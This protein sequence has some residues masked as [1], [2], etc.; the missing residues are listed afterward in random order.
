MAD[1]GQE[2]FIPSVS[3]I[4]SPA[5]RPTENF[6][7]QREDPP[8]PPATVG[9]YFTP[10]EAQRRFAQYL[11]IE[12]T[13]NDVLMPSDDPRVYTYQMANG[14][15]Y[16]VPAYEEVLQERRSV[17]EAF[18]HLVDNFP[19]RTEVED[20][21]L[22]LPQAAYGAV[23]NMV[24]GQGTYEDV[25]GTATGMVGLRPLTR[26]RGEEPPTAPRREEPDGPD[27]WDGVDDNAVD[28][29][30]EPIGDDPLEDLNIQ[31]DPED[32]PLAPT[33]QGQEVVAINDLWEQQPFRPDENWDLPDD[34]A[35][36]DVPTGNQRPLGVNTQ[37]EGDWR[38]P[39]APLREGKK[40][41][42][43]P[44]YPPRDYT[45]NGYEPQD[46]IVFRS[47][48]REFV[49]GVQIPAQGIKGSQFLKMLQDNPSIRN[50]EVSYLNLGISPEARYTREELQQLVDSRV[51]QVEAYFT[52]QYF[53]YQR[54][55]VR[56]PQQD[57][58]EIVIS[59][60]PQ[61]P[62]GQFRA[63]SQHYDENTLA[64]ARVSVRSPEGGDFSNE[65]VLVEEMQSDLIQKGW[66]EPRKPDN[67]TFS[68][69]I[70]SEDVWTSRSGGYYSDVSLL[71]AELK[72]LDK[73]VEEATGR[74]ILAGGY[75]PY[76]VTSQLTRRL[77]EEVEERLTRQNIQ[78]FVLDYLDYL[79]NNEPSIWDAATAPP[80]RTTQESTRLIAE[81]LISYADRM[82]VDEIVFPPLER[83]AAERFQVGSKD[84]QKALTPGSG[85]HQT[86]VT[87][88]K[89]VIQEMQNELGEDAIRVYSREIPYGSGNTPIVNFEAARDDW[90]DLQ[91]MRNRYRR[92][93]P[94]ETP[95]QINQRVAD[96]L[97]GN[98]A[99]QADEGT[100]LDEYIRFY[101][102]DFMFAV[103]LDEF[104]EGNARM[105]DSVLPREGVAI[106]IGG[107]RNTHNLQYPRFAEGGLV[108]Q[109]RSAF[110]EIA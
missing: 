72:L 106:N 76:S 62:S 103:D 66:E 9:N 56:D 83:I 20:M 31:W 105:S 14:N 71:E 24:T 19:S 59:A 42:T 90:N 27:L 17:G 79:S 61:D 101:G 26:P 34:I 100:M 64:H 55:P 38:V 53:N 97:Q 67:R 13:P 3:E 92:E 21:M 8:A 110:G 60:S 70:M 32:E 80:I 58:K 40:M 23:S 6:I 39:P 22:G 49:A 99:L 29:D 85:F 94:D 74:G 95:Q 68:E 45:P 2:E 93:F 10:E 1:Y 46:T 18:N 107:L 7:P 57:Y 47:P 44:L 77:P 81:S 12:S 108:T 33:G 5:P 104:Y 84:Y 16:H 65:Y 52:D 87:S 88:L 35:Q 30:F 41:P 50:S 73:D 102:N 109:T 48:V 89:K 96:N 4:P 11:P 51:P 98:I 86:Y 37:L 36:M 63:N 43:V 91:L 78:L 75:T 28:A 15:I 82:G 54:Q 25:I 69:W